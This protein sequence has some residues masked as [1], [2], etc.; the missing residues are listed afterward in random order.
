M[1]DLKER[2]SGEKPSKLEQK[3]Q[4][5]SWLSWERNLELLLTGQLCYQYII[6]NLPLSAYS[7]KDKIRHYR[8]AWQAPDVEGK[9]IEG[10]EEI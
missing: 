6:L 7:T 8:G 10:G 3:K 9:T 4:Q 2:E 1:G 5:K